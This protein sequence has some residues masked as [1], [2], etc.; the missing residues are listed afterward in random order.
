MK[1]SNKE[2][3]QFSK[4]FAIRR[5]VREN[6]ATTSIRRYALTFFHTMDCFFLIRVV[7]SIIV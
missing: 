4:F 7:K 1:L 2:P 6:A 3:P 5:G